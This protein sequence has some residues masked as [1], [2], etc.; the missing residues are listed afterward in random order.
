LYLV[1][2]FPSPTTS[3]ILIQNLFDKGDQVIV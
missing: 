2:G 3:S 1:P